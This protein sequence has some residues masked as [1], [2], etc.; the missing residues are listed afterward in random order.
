[1]GSGLSWSP[2]DEPQALNP[3]DNFFTVTV[4]PGGT[5]IDGFG[6]DA[7]GNGWY[8]YPEFGW[9]NI[10]FYDHPFSYDRY[11]IVHIEM[12]AFPLDAGPA[13]IE[14]AVNWST[15]LWSLEGN[16]PGERR[17]PLPEDGAEEMWIGRHTVFA[18]EQFGGHYSFDFVLDNYNPEWVSIDVRGFNFIIPEGIITHECVAQQ[19]EQLDLAFVI[20]GGEASCC[21]IRGDVNHNGTGPDIAD[22]VYLANF[23]FQG[24][25]PPPC[26][27]P[28][29]SG[30]YSECDMNGDG[31]G[32]NIADLVY[33]VT[34][35]FQGGPAPVPCP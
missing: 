31:V 4:D 1:M 12:D 11:K 7:Y 13:F 33:L 5:V 24:G 27:E 29:G 21:I 35:M 9:W 32:P 6:Q 3:I 15:D 8:F 30:Y 17:P 34:Y 10:W 23:M 26:E 20:T 25:S 19:Q 16:P 2:L 22:L 14:L 18:A 28:P